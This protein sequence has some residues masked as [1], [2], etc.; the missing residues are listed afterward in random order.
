MRRNK[1]SFRARWT[2][3]LHFLFINGVIGVQ[4]LPIFFTNFF[5]FKIILIKRIDCAPWE[6]LFYKTKKF[7][8][9]NPSTRRE[10]FSMKDVLNRKSIIG[11]EDFFPVLNEHFGSPKNVEISWSVQLSKT[12]DT[13]ADKNTILIITTSLYGW[14]PIEII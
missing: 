7:S 14:Y 8:K 3:A 1:S 5:F 13:F 12:R 6:V 10:S 4:I 11:L 9:L 2:L